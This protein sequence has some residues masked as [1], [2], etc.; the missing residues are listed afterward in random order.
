MLENNHKVFKKTL[1]FLRGG[2][3]SL[4][5]IYVQINAGKLTLD[6]HVV[7]VYTVVLEE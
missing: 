4:Q 5:N 7:Q 6:T 1:L 2:E 3:K